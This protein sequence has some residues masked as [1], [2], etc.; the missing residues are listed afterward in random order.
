VRPV[1]PRVGL[2]EIQV[3]EEQEEF[4][5]LAATPLT[6]QDGSVAILTRW[7]FTPAERAAVAAGEDLFLEFAA[8]QMTPVHLRTG[9]P[10]WAGEGAG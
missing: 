1:A 7:T 8:R 5:P 4:S 2:P 3:A 9:P 10:E 6:Y